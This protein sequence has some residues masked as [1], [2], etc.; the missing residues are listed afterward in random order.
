MDVP[1]APSAAERA[2]SAV[3]CSPGMAGDWGAEV[4]DGAV[5]GGEMMQQASAVSTAIHQPASC[6]AMRPRGA[7][8]FCRSSHRALWWYGLPWVG[9]RQT[10]WRGAL[11]RRGRPERGW[12]A[13]LGA[14]VRRGGRGWLETSTARWKYVLVL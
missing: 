7:D 10:A 2:P 5:G 3:L 6:Y 4:G 9:G 12:D 13:L 11:A 1:A 8:Q 14:C